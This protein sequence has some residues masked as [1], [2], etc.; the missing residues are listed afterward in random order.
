MKSRFAFLLCSGLLMFGAAPLQAAVPLASPEQDRNAKQAKPPAGRA[1]VYVYRLNDGNPK[2]APGIWLN[3]R[4]SGNLDPNT[5]RMWAASA[6]R[7]EIRAGQAGA[8]PL[9]IKCENGKIYFVQL[10]VNADGSMGL[11][12][13]P[14]DKGRAEVQTAHFILDPAPVAAAAAVPAASTKKEAPVTSQTPE[15]ADALGVTLTLKL[16]SF[17]M[18]SKNQTINSASLQ[19]STSSI[20]YGFEGEW[21]HE[22]GYAV[23][24]ELFGHSQDYTVTASTQSGDVALSYIFINAKKYFQTGTFMQPYIGIGIGRSAASYSAGSSGGVTSNVDSNAAQGMAGVIF[25]WQYVDLYTEY[26]Y[27]HDKYSYGGEVN[28]SANGLFAGVS[29]HF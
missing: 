24:L 5:F 3:T 11:S 7:L 19:T 20:V 16:G 17:Q 21:R 18:L 22:S 28:A 29:A 4:A 6:G 8:T 15:Q 1:L 25:R 2:V 27:L 26:K 14:D 23:G 12:Q 13:M 9:T 10:V